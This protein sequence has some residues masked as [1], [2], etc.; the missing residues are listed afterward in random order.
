MKKIMIFIVLSGFSFIA[1][2]VFFPQRIIFTA[3]LCSVQDVE[4][5]LEQ[6]ISPNTQDNDGWSALHNAVRGSN[7]GVVRALLKHGADP[8]VQDNM[9]S[10]PLHCAALNG[11]IEAIEVLLYYGADP[12]LENRFFETPID[13]AED[14]ETLEVL[15]DDGQ[16]I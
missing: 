13:V 8:N 4:A 15:L 16:S 14:D 6:G 9:Y 10:S 2:P 5:L 7:I 11:D 3:C 1:L 12:Y